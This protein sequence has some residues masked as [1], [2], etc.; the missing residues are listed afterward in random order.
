[1]SQQHTPGPWRAVNGK[2][3]NRTG[4]HF[5]AD[6]GSLAAHPAPKDGAA[7]IVANARLIAA[8]PELLEALRFVLEDARKYRGQVSA[9]TLRILDEVVA[10]AE[11]GAS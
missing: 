5:I 10:K 4:S 11:G 9:V 8:A 2:V 7:E 6:C 1:M 3:T